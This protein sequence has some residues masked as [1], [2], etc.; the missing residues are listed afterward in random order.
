MIQIQGLRKAFGSVVAVDGL[1]LSVEDGR[2]T[3]LLGPNG[4]G[5]ST[6]IHCVV[7]LAK[8]DAGRIHIS[9]Y[10]TREDPVAAKRTFSYV[11]EV[12]NLYQALTPDEFLALKGRLFG[13]DEPRIAASIER[14]LDGFGLGDRRSQ[15]MSGFSK[16]M[17]Q[18]V[19]IAAA[20]LT[21]PRNLVLDEPLSGLDVETTFV[22]KEVLREFAATGGAVLYCSH[23]LDVVE[24]LADRVAVLDH[25]K[26]QAIGTMDELRAQTGGEASRL[27][28][29]FRQLTD[30]ADPVARARAILGRDHP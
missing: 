11:P 23:M 10:D 25:G 17:T 24:N 21:E 19:A 4:A 15:P 28:S 27:E 2:I 9:G 6:T 5:K 18:K 13:L 12:A 29:L 30:A 3:A 20:L 1:D 16:G 14:L 8:P 7:G 22:L 26:L